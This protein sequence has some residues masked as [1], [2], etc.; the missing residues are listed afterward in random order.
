[1]EPLVSLADQDSTPMPEFALLVE[2]IAQSVTQHP[3]VHAQS[4][5]SEMLRA[6]EVI[7]LVSNSNL[8]LN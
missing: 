6:A 7:A 1:M 8:F 2:P 4:D 5:S 3:A